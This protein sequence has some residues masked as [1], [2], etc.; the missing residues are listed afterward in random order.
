V[1]LGQNWPGGLGQCSAELHC[2]TG[3]AWLT[4][5]FYSDDFL[6]IQMIQ[7]CKIRNWYLQN[8]KKFQTWPVGGLLQM[9]QTSFLTKRQNHSIF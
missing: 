6:N 4:Y 2:S 3:P 7:T 1:Q 8:F 9:E 5:F